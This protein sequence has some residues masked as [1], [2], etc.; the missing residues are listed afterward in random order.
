MHQQQITVLSLRK[1]GAGFKT[2]LDGEG[3]QWVD[4]PENLRG[5]LEWKGSYQIGWKKNPKKTGGWFYNLTSVGEAN[6]TAGA[7]PPP[8]KGNGTAPPHNYKDLDIATQA[9]AKVFGPLIVA[10]EIEGEISPEA[11]AEIMTRCEAGVKRWWR[12]RSVVAPPATPPQPPR[13][14]PVEDIED[15]F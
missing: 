5:R 3:E 8:A 6:Q 4:I 14:D 11:I 1:D 9:V 2:N 7:P 12:S 13:N 10:R 15:T